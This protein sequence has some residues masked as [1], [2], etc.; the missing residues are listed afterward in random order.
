[1]SELMA[2]SDIKALVADILREAT[3][4]GATSA[5]VD[6][7][8]NKG[9]SV[10]ARQGDVE[11]IEYHQDKAISIT[12]YRGHRSGSSSLSD[13]RPE[14]IRSAVQAAYHIAQ[15]TDEDPFSGLANKDQMAWDYPAVDVA[16]P[17]DMTVERAIEETKACEALA[18]GYDKRLSSDGVTLSTGGGWSVYGNTHGFMGAFRATRHDMSCMLIASQNDE[19]QRDY[20]YTVSCDASLLLSIRD[21]AADAAARA[22][23]RL[24]AKSLS[25]RNVPVIFAAEEARGLLGHFL[26][27]ISGRNLYK[28]SSFLL[29]QLG[30]SIFPDFISLDERPFL[31][32][33]LGSS[34]FDNDGV[35][36]RNQFFVE[37]GV[38]KNYLLSAYSARKLGLTT[39]GNAGGAHNLFVTTGERS[40]SELLKHMGRGLLITELMGQG[41]NIITGD[42]SRGASG[43]W[44]ENGEIQHAVEEVTIAGNLKDMYANMVEVGNDV[45]VR[46][47]IRTGSILINN[48]MVA[49]G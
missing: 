13:I 35:A 43:F 18:L 37:N 14:A 12:V 4:Q 26:A 17:W 6:M 9:F 31:A 19:M 32:K 47:N 45:D 7:G 46:G 1:M 23:R 39:T 48:M 16:Y 44:I 21:V 29:D 11:S 38:L 5:E 24:N 20:S 41:V 42:Y 40:L 36:T 8:V 25:T 30:Q 34:P 28:K 10:T 22:I 3:D 15:F 27:A 33:S 2:E 49:G